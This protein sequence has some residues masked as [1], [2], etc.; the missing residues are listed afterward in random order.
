M[1]IFLGVTR[2]PSPRE[3]HI[4][5]P[6][7]QRGA[8]FVASA[9]ETIR[10]ICLGKE[11]RLLIIVGPCSIHDVE[12]S[13]E[14]ARRLKALANSVGESCFLVMRAYIEK[15]RTRTGWRGLVHDPLLNESH[16]I[17]EGL[18][19][20]RRFLSALVDLQIP[21]ATEFVTPHAS[22]YF[23]DL[24]S[25][26]CIGARTSASQPHRLLAS[27][28]QMPVGFKNSIDG[29][30]DSAISGI[31]L[32]RRPQVF[33]HVDEEGR[34][35][36]CFSRG[37]PA[38]HIVLRGS[39]S[40]SNYDEN[41]IAAVLSKLRRLELPSRLI[42]DCS[43]GNCQ[44]HYEKQK[45]TFQSLLEQIEKGSQHICGLML[46]SHLEAGSQPLEQNPHNLL[47]GVS[48][49]DPCLDFESTARL[50]EEAAALTHH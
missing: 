48:I 38:A 6:L 17:A 46:E 47:P 24:I 42:V 50:I 32:A 21:A 44:K 39:H 16:E 13:L 35:A 11:R 34:L 27:H 10:R 29:N 49:T 36:R 14:Y 26:G 31:L 20:A 3:L 18:S 23:E 28:L 41:S 15:P 33:L 25:W 7:S 12:A 30:V 37:N 1:D 19:R 8:Q 43:H 9:R 45:E 40:G 4:Q 22:P 2:I 5:F